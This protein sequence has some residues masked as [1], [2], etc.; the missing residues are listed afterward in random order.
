[1]TSTHKTYTNLDAFNF[2]IICFKSEISW[3]ITSL[4][5]I[6]GGFGFLRRIEEPATWR[7]WTWL[8]GLE[9]L[10][11]G[12]SFQLFLGGAIFFSIPP[13]HWKIGKKQHFICSNLTLFIF[14]FFLSFFSLFFFFFFFS[15]FFL[16]FL[17]PWGGGDGPQPPQ[18]TPL[19][20]M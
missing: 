13:D 15:F 12:A 9:A 14:P 3:F 18:M 10:P 4:M 5:S 20:A 8:T 19:V 1:M 6:G 2:S 11:S 16:F 7:T 17:F